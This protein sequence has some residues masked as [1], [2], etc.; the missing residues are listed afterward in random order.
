MN[1][2]IQ[3]PMVTAFGKLLWGTIYWRV[4][5][6]IWTIKSALNLF[7][8]SKEPPDLRAINRKGKSVQ[9]CFLQDWVSLNLME[10][11]QENAMDRERIIK[12][13]IFE[14]VHDISTSVRN[15]QLTR[16]TLCKCR[17]GLSFRIW[18]HLMR[19]KPTW[20]W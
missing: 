13:F 17:R 16:L 11:E 5:H 12:Y 7:S 18:C 9:V 8:L 4:S 6:K 2:N 10:L 3:W 15:M 14:D 1:A 19:K 20:R